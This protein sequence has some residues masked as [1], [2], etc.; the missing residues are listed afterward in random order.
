MVK[1]EID[2]SSC[3]LCEKCTRI[4]SPAL[5]RKDNETKQIQ[6]HDSEYCIQCGHCA[7]VCPTDSVIHSVFPY[8]TV[9]SFDPHELPTA[10]SL[11]LL[12][13][14][15]RSNRAFSSMAIP[16]EYLERILGA[17]HRAPTA[18]NEQEL[19][20]TIVTD[21][22]A[23]H[24]ISAFTLDVFSGILKLIKPLKSILKLFIPD[25]TALIPEFEGMVTDFSKGKDWVL[26]DAKAV[27]FIHAPQSARFGRQDANLAYQ[28]AS[29]LAEA[30]GVAHFYTGF[31]CIANDYDSRKKRLNKLLQIEGN[32]HAGMAL[33]MP[34][35]RF[36][37]YIDRKP[38]KVN[39]I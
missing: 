1:I 7:A 34:S 12:I 26:R 17:A 35:F 10:D 2:Q 16:K 27:I 31:V 36:D 15:R 33:G 9:H 5:F 20:Y 4:C 21:P 38:V 14:A 29:L 23:L 18:S 32:I 37:K 6:V 39:W 11:E 28:N 13:K 3:I 8:S 25:V 30:L 24:Q 22:E 19:S